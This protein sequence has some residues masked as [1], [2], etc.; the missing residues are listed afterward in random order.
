MTGYSPADHSLSSTSSSP[1][2]YD[3]T[4]EMTK[5]ELT[6]DNTRL[7]GV[8]TM[9]WNLVNEGKHYIQRMG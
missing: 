3:C 8:L 5:K 4:I 9:T 7:E 2:P 1:S 6:H